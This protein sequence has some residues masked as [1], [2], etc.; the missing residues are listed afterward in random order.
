M[1]IILHLFLIF[2]LT[3][4]TQIGG[5]VY[6]LALI[7]AAQVK[8]KWRFKQFSLFLGFY[9][10]ATF[11][12]V[13]LLAPLGGREP[14]SH[15]YNITATNYLTVLLNR[16]YVRPALNQV[17]VTTA[18]SLEPTGVQLRYLDANFPFFNGFPLLPHLSHSDGKKIDLSLVY[19]TKDHELTTLQKSR[20][21][22]GA[23]VGPKSH[24]VDQIKKCIS[25]G[26]WQY[27]FPKYLTL[28]QI[29]PELI[30]S[31]LGTK[32]LVKQLLKQQ[33]VRKIFI[34]PHLKN[35]LGLSS[36]RVRYHGCR[37]VRHD[38]HI[39]VQL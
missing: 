39:H 22:Y 12:I 4:L 3:I 33:A 37:A 14:V 19:E 32:L 25:G 2:L 8:S 16:N 26:Y 10:I 38:D 11:L 7:V 17:L 21:G 29:N 9:T 1:K 6:L 27:D 28:G 20:S 23:F 18:K 30:F 31:E 15:N 5:I 35:R 34:E 13:P 24:E 36:N